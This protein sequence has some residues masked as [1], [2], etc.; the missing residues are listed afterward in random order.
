M[1]AISNSLAM[2][3]YPSWVWS[4]SRDHFFLIFGLNHVV[5]MGETRHF[6]FGDY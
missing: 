6:Q 1:Y 5:G 3:S 2:T 4:R